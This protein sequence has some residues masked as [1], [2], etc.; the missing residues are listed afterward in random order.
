MAD[1]QE[2]VKP[3]RYD[4]YKFD[5]ARIAKLF[6]DLDVNNDGR[7]DVKELSSG[8]KRLGVKHMP[9]QAEVKSSALIRLD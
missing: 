7:I 2:G 9:G 3:D 8:L 1:E 5:E 4:G 6:K